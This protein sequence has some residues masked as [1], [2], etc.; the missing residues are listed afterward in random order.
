MLPKPDGIP[1]QV[2]PGQ[3]LEPLQSPDE[4]ANRNFSKDH[5]SMPID[6]DVGTGSHQMLFGMF[7]GLD[8]CLIALRHQCF[9]QCLDGDNPG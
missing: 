3:C 5:R 9:Q 8:R 2:R 4:P 7:D 1:V 6:S